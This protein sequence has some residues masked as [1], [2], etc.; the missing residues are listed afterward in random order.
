MVYDKLKKIIR[1]LKKIDDIYIVDR[2]T[3][4]FINKAIL[5]LEVAQ[6]RVKPE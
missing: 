1:D 4:E 5:P 2:K 6:S 3:V